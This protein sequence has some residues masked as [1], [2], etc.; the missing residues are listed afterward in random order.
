MRLRGY[1]V[2]EMKMIF[3]TRGAFTRF[4]LLSESG[5]PLGC[6]FGLSGGAPKCAVIGLGRNFYESHRP[7][8]KEPF[9]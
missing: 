7:T 5:E 4:V 8:S 3:L 9:R 2:P 6:I 1:I